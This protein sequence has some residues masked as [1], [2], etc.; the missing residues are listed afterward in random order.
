MDYSVINQWFYEASA[1][2][3]LSRAWL[4][5]GILGLLLPILLSGL[6]GNDEGC[7]AYGRIRLPGIAGRNGSGSLITVI[8]KSAS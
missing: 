7:L 1:A 2:S 3:W 4:L 6:K 5:V 8:S